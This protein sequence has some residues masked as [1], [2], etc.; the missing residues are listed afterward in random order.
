M[1]K[2]QKRIQ[3]STM[4]R[5][6]RL[7]KRRQRRLV[8]LF[9]LCA[10]VFA[11]YSLI[12]PAPTVQAVSPNI[13]ISQI[14][15][16][17]GNTGAT[18]NQDF[19][20]LYNRSSVSV[21]ITGWTLQ[22]ASATGNFSTAANNFLTLSGTIGPGQ[23]F[24]VA[25]STVG[26]NGV[27]LPTPDQ[28]VNFNMAAGAGKVSLR[29]TSPGFNGV[30]C[31]GGSPN[32][33]DASIVDFVGYGATANCY[34]GAGPTPVPNATT[35]VIR[36]SN[37]AGV[38]GT[39]GCQDTDNNSA[40]FQLQSPPTPR[41]S[42]T[43]AATCNV[44]EFSIAFDNSGQGCDFSVLG[45]LP[46][47]TFTWSHTL[48]SGDS[49][50]LVVGVS[51]F[52]TLAVLPGVRVTGVR[53]VETN[54]ALTRV[55]DGLGT[56]SD[57]KSGVD[58]F[59]IKEPLP[60][61]GTYTIEVSLGA[62]VEYA[63]GGSV[64]FN[65]VN[66]TTPNR[67]FAAGTN[68]ATG[69]STTPTITT[70]PSATNEIVVDTVGTAFGTPPNILTP[71]ASQTERWNGKFC[72][73]PPPANEPDLTLNSIGAGST[74]PG[75]ATTTMSWTQNNSQPWVIEAISLIPLAPTEVEV[76]SFDALQTNAGV[77]L[78][79]ETGYEVNNL[80]FNL[81]REQNGKRTRLNPSLI[82][83]SALMTGQGTRLT[84]GQSY[85]WLDS[86]SRNRE[87]VQYWL[88]DTD[89]NGTRKLHGPILP[90][91]NDGLE[92]SD[93]EQA[94]LLSQLNL[95]SAETASVTSYPAALAQ[96]TEQQLTEEREMQA[97]SSPLPLKRRLT[98]MLLLRNNDLL[99]AVLEE[100]APVKRQSTSV[101]HDDQPIRQRALAAGAAVKIAIRQP[102]WYR[103]TP[104]EL[105]AAGIN[106]N[107]DPSL[108]QLYGD[109]VEQAILQTGENKQL[110]AHSTIE[111]Y[112]TAIDT[113]TSDTRTYWLVVGSKPGK[114]IKHE[115]DPGG[116][117]IPFVEMD[118]SWWM[119][120]PPARA[121]S[122]PKP[123]QAI[124]PATPAAPAAINPAPPAA[125][126]IIVPGVMLILPRETSTE[127]SAEAPKA[128]KK[129][130]AARKKTARKLLKDRHHARSSQKKAQAD[131]SSSGFAY[132]VERKD[133]SVY[134]SA[135]LNGEGDNF[136]GPVITATPVKQ[137]MSLRGIDTSSSNPATLEVSVQ[138]GT[139]QSHQVRVEFNGTEVGVLS[140]TNQERAVK[141]FQ[142]PRAWLAEGDN[143][144]TLTSTGGESDV[145]VLDYL[146]LTYWHA[147][148][149]DNDH[150][151]FTSDH[152]T[153]ISIDGFT[154]PQIKVF[155]ISDQDEVGQLGVKVSPKGSGYSVKIPGGSGRT[156]T[157]IAL[158]EG[159]TKSPA[160]ITFNEPS[161]LSHTENRADF[162]IL[163]HKDFLEAV[164][165][166]ADLRR[167]QGLEVKV[168]NV[169]DVYDEFSYGA[170]SRQAVRDFFLWT[171]TNWQR[172][173]GYALLV[174][175][176]SADPRNYLNKGFQDYVPTRMVDTKLFETASDDAL[177]DF[178]SDGIADIAIGR[179]PVQTLEQAQKVVAKIT[180][181][182]PGQ[183]GDGALLVSD[184]L[185]G[186][187]FEAANNRIRDLLPSNMA[188][189][190]VNR[191]DR[192]P[193][194]VRDDI[195]AGIN[196]GPQIVNYA[197]HGSVEVWTGAGILR[198]S[199]K[200]SL[201]NGSRL[202]LVLTMTCLN[203]FFQDVFTESLAEALIKADGGGAVAV[204]ASSGMTEPDRQALVDQQLIR[205]LFTTEQSPTLGDAV[206][207]AKQAT[208]D[209]D[210]RRTW[211]LFGD[212]TMRIR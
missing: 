33:N 38:A 136:F 119:E 25:A 8:V 96:K 86:S 166:L 90:A 116:I 57:A 190:T 53:I 14:Y 156:R 6:S 185:E 118:V 32:P 59:L 23:Y 24:L 78:R 155:D 99:D 135:L 47:R 175:D 69:T 89:L 112:A 121:T 161:S 5:L 130:K 68:R 63:V 187:D 49:Q 138:G 208:A 114:R 212:P 44:G 127:V 180:G 176:A 56:S 87:S 139:V 169:E 31:P 124:K 125:P 75:S 93:K 144:V 17:G 201:T 148:R 100:S 160:G 37:T 149:A 72:D 16:A 210:V 170:H 71:D 84:A 108:L 195:L 147:Y 162:V 143:T 106:P 13:V 183:S 150:L 67:A 3:Y 189:T 181:Y 104:A 43:A 172:A 146:R 171:K 115:N 193:A 177:V 45:G 41:N 62:G 152:T 105:V 111:F 110:D 95:S 4:L 163:T 140:F 102:G 39:T 128:K 206:R 202:P 109:G 188:V 198:S 34:E 182:V 129:K 54:Q 61:A 12:S 20:E 117:S 48:G 26:A 154:S 107:V 79:W 97:Q 66:Q 92:A 28:S 15:G 209:M 199:D 122:A 168:V 60:A 1:N 98:S 29:N 70:V 167:S 103:L 157:L 36:K 101:Y 173:P 123:Q 194:Q 80:G 51:T 151:T 120:T 165:P 9:F 131:S 141:S 82:A 88:E 211:I 204:W 132:T 7:A 207:G 137:S 191:R 46:A 91:A 184:H 73:G 133:R 85:S 153:P 205:L 52:S 164:K 200:T 196:Q 22:Y 2:H 113:P 142:I 55:D 158:T 197:G 40:D 159:Q 179:L 58:M 30:S 65:G 94:M 21:N 134:F 81:Y 42:A 50:V 74:R 18:Y 192:A 27:A 174:G 11:G 126:K 35:S 64:S 186:Y 83:G 77:L 76:A 19:I 145:N 203:G 178:N 10:L